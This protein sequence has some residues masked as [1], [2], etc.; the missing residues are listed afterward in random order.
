MAAKGATGNVACDHYHQWKADV[1]LMRSMGLKHY[2]FSI[3]WPRLFPTGASSGKPNPEGVAFYSNLIDELLAAGITP[4]VTL[5]HWDLPQA[6]L[7]PPRINGWWSRDRDGKPNG[8]ILPA[9]LHYADTCFSLFGDRVKTWATF[10]EAWTFTYLSSGLGK[11]PSIEEFNNMERD[12]W[13]AG[14]NVLNA[15]AAAVHLYRAKFYTQ[16]GKIGITNNQ[17]WREP[18]TDSPEDAAATERSLE[19]QLGWFAEP[20]FGGNGDYPPA[21]R[22]LY[23][24][25]LPEFTVEEKRKINNSADFFGLN[26]YGTGLGSFDPTTGSNDKSYMKSWEGPMFVQGQS[27][28]LYSAAWGFRKLLNWVSRRYG[29]DLPIYIT[30]GGWSMAADTTA[31]GIGDRQRLEYYANYTSEMGRAISEDGVNV[32]AYY[33][34]SLMDNFE[35]EQGFRERFGTTFNDFALRLDRLGKPSNEPT[36][37]RQVRTRKMSSCWLEAVWRSNELV[38]PDAFEGCVPQ[39][40][41]AGKYSLPGGAD[42]HMEINIGPFPDM[43]YITGSHKLDGTTGKCDESAGVSWGP[44]PANLSAGT[45][46]ADFSVMGL[47]GN[48]AGYWNR[49]DRAI[50]WGDGGVWTATDGPLWLT[51]PKEG[52]RPQRGGAGRPV[53]LALSAQAA[54][55]VALASLLWGSAA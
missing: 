44:T 39:G 24:D 40:V 51:A 28:W 48:L 26:H 52:G 18:K 38:D 5:Y 9:W 50:H 1:A 47:P 23:G 12:P 17:D 35:W 13:I 41:F 8:E 19:F 36:Q 49:E 7:D 11:A 34:W 22:K 25:R 16:G 3:S 31:E 15:H 14:H 27:G 32:K 46:I 30:E 20:I 21:M 6:L 54:L 29:K 33:A 55:L 45:L 10:N 43:A 53:P 37:G 4:F 42:C 2:R